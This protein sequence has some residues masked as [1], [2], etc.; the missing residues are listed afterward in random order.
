[1]SVRGSEAWESDGNPG[2]EWELLTLPETPSVMSSYHTLLGFEVIGESLEKLP[3][4]PARDPKEAI[5]NMLAEF[6]VT[7]S[8]ICMRTQCW[9][10]TAHSH[11]TG[12]LWIFHYG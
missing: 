9:R 8:A 2:M 11:R 4:S 7:F 3:W 10:V 5:A 6:A 1:M 12:L